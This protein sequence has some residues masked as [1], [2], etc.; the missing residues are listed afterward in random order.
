MSVKELSC[1]QKKVPFLPET[2]KLEERSFFQTSQS[3]ATFTEVLGW[4]GL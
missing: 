3:L 1:R 4:S 2:G